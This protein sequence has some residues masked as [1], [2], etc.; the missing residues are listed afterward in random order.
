MKAAPFNYLITLIIVGLAVWAA[1]SLYSRYVTNP[2]TRDGQ[3]RANIVGIAPRVSGPIIQVAVRDNQPVRKGDLLFEIDPS[4]FQ[5]QVDIAAGQVQ[6]DEATF[7]QQQQN[8]DRQTDLFRTRVN[9]LQD[10]Q[11]A[12]DSF[13]AAR[14]QL[15]SA[16]ANLA[17]ARLNLSYTKV[18]APV[19]GFV[20]NMNTSP[21]T[22]VTAGLQ[23]MAL[24]DTSSYWVAGY[25]KE[26]QL[27]HIKVGQKATI[28]MI[29]YE[30]QPFQGV[31]RSVGW[32]VYVQNGSG[33]SSTALLPSVNPTIDWVRLPQRFPVRI[34]VV[35]E[36]PVPLRIGQ[37][38]SV[39]MTTSFSPGE[40][41]EIAEFR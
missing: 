5:A 3:V 28:T 20:T 24:V 22:Y 2:W 29:G 8:L 31:V 4:D 35:G 33:S 37:T 14:A 10:F 1:V 39:A 27:P 17:L 12:Q 30:N 32:G 11:N 15:A 23:L 40:S 18:F 38:V 9:A 25:F 7:K 41:K 6:N 34:Q 16:K 21:G 19:D 13:A 36:T 26:T